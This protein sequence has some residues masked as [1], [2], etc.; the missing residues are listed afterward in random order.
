MN[1]E[2]N[3]SLADSTEYDIY[4]LLSRTRWCMMTQE[5]TCSNKRTYRTNM[6]W[7]KEL[8]ENRSVEDETT[9]CGLKNSIKD[10]VFTQ[11]SYVIHMVC[12]TP[13]VKNNSLNLLS[14]VHL[15]GQL[16]C[17]TLPNM[18]PAVFLVRTELS[19]C[20]WF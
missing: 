18:S 2:T 8:E 10:T 9:G 14:F 12:I 4:L 6:S 1:A 7:K 15:L 20:L 19:G 13:V 16:I 3:S 5:W 11:N 17:P